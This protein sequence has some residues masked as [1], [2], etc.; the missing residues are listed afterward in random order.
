M[1]LQIVGLNHKTAPLELREKLAFKEPG[2]V[3]G[4]RNLVDGAKIRE[5]LILS[6][7]NRVEILLE[8]DSSAAFSQTVEFLAAGK[9]VA[10]RIFTE[11]LYHFSDD[12][13]VRHLFRVASSLDSMIVGEGQILRQVRNAYALSVEA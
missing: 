11:H 4:L 3:A 1:S 6:T 7:C 12:R 13:A 8:G 2:C 5:A 10:P 9:G